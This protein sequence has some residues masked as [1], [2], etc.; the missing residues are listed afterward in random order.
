VSGL[1]G[2]WQGRRLPRRTMLRGV[3]LTGAGLAGAALIGCGSRGPAATGSAPGGAPVGAGNTVGTATA[4]AASANAKKGGRLQVYASATAPNLDPMLSISIHTHQR[5]SLVYSNLVEMRRGP[6][7]IYDTVIGPDLAQSWEATPDGL[8]WTFKMRSGAKWAN[9]APMTGRVVNAEDVV[10]TMRRNLA[11]EN[12]NIARYEMLDGPPKAIDAT[13]VQFKLKYPHPGFLFNMASEPAEIQPREAVEKNGDLKNWGAGSG[14]F[15]MTKYDAQTAATYVKNPDYYDAAN[16]HL[17]GVD[18]TVIPDKATAIANF[19]SGQIDALGSAITHALLPADI[20]AVMKSVPKAQRTDF[21]TPS[22]SAFAMNSKSA[23][24]KDL[25]VRQAVNMVM[26]RKAHIAALSGGQGAITGTFPFHRFPEYALPDA[27]IQALT[28]TDVAEAKKLMA[29]AG[30]ENGFTA[31]IMWQPPQQASLN[32][33]VEMLKQIGIKLDTASEAVDYP[34]WVSKT[35]NGQYSDFAEW[36]Y[37]V[38]SIWEYVNGLHR[39]GGNR[40][41]PATNNPEL[42]GMIDKLLRTTKPEDQQT[43]VKD[44]ERYVLTKSL[45]IVPLTVSATALVEQP[46]LRDFKPGYGAMGGVYMSP[47]LRRAWLDK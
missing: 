43:M 22:Q 29:A 39:T 5:I 23:L 27:E 30:V 1:N 18:W 42:D 31:K 34:A 28:K 6:Q 38:G 2:F 33:H 24:L 21:Y 47:H 4:E 32:V 41:G 40:N 20:E 36:G 9:V 13:T 15:I 10:Y 3:A 45:Y 26:D 16:V 46:H 35:Y 44:I 12:G 37:L 11:P 19:R 25:R 7:G 14:P 8:T 17:E